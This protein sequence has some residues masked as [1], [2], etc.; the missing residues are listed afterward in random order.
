MLLGFG[1]EGA[2]DLP[3]CSHAARSAEPSMASGLLEPC[4]FATASCGDI[5]AEE[6]VMIAKSRWLLMALALMACGTIHAAEEPKP[7]APAAGLAVGELLPAFESTDEQGLPWKSADHV[8]KKVLVLY[9]YP[10]DFTGGCIKQVEAYREGLA[11]LEELGVEL[12]GVS[13]DEVAT[14]KLFRE[15]HDLKH[16]LLADSRG[17]LAK[18]VGIPVSA[19]DRVRPRNADRQSLVDAAGKRIIFQRP[20]TLA[21]WTLIVDKDGKIAALRN[22]VDPVTDSEEVRKIVE[23]LP[24]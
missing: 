18:L 22:I 16:T 12:V 15:T 23:K 8:G 7:E 13:G 24:R 2:D 19:G 11:K 20:V 6:S 9:F 10:G 3:K 21:R 4:Y 14:H 5:H 17:E 1:S